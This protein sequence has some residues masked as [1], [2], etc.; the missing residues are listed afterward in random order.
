MKLLAAWIE[1]HYDELMA[2]WALAVKG[3]QVFKIGTA[4]FLKSFRTGIISGR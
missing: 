4:L 1:I 3:E 2:N